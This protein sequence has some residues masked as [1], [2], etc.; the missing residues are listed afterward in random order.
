M[1][2]RIFAFCELLG[3]ILFVS[4]CGCKEDEFGDWLELEVP[5]S[6]LSK[7]DTL[8]PGDTL[9][10]NADFDKAVQV[11]SNYSPIVLNGFNFFTKLNISEVSDTFERYD[12]DVSLF[13]EIGSIEVL[14][15]AT[16]TAYPINYVEYRDGYRF[17]GGIVFEETGLF[18]VGFSTQ[19]Q[20]YDNYDHPAVYE[21]G[22]NRRS[23]IHVHYPNRS[24]TRKNYEELFLKTNVGYML[25]LY[26][27]QR[28]LDLGGHTILVK[29]P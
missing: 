4:A 6:T 29:E 21:C 5:I 24:S 26:D 10:I 9:W 13:T 15:L 27:Y 11:R 22:K 17:R 12:V 16:A 14:P 25:E 20:L 8:H 28:Y 23:E 2:S 3:L 1:A 7:K 18:F 19:S